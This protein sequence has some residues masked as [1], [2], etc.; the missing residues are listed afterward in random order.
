M[1]EYHKPVEPVKAPTKAVEI[2]KP[3]ESVVNEDALDS[4]LREFEEDVPKKKKAAVE[5]NDMLGDG[6]ITDQKAV[7]ASESTDA[8]EED[9]TDPFDYL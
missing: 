1:A 4:I 6:A 5:Q 9:G 7:K 3:V 2:P 8:G